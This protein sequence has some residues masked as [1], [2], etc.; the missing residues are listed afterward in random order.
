MAHQWIHGGFCQPPPTPLTPLPTN[1]SPSAGMNPW[2]YA[3]QAPQSQATLDWT[4]R[5]YWSNPWVVDPDATSQVDLN[6]TQ[7]TDHT[8]VS[9][10]EVWEEHYDQSVTP[11]ENLAADFWDGPAYIP[12]P[13]VH[14][15]DQVGDI[16]FQ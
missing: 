10:H 4:N 9:Q 8:N 13:A 14:H 12:P 16:P 6:S 7:S 1:S 2:A 3:T 11:S 5:A 15:E